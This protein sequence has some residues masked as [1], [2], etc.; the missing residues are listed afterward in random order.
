MNV[1]L[2]VLRRDDIKVKLQKPWDAMAIGTRKHYQ[3]N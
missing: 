1:A 2:I 3:T